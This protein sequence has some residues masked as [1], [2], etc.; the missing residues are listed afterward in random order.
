MSQVGFFS[1]WSHQIYSDKNT[2]SL[3]MKESTR[4]RINVESS[5]LREVRIQ[6]KSRPHKPLPAS[7]ANVLHWNVF[8]ISL[9]T[10]IKAEWSK[11]MNSRV[12][13][14]HFQRNVKSQKWSTSATQQESLK[15][16][17]LSCFEALKQLVPTEQAFIKSF[18]N[19]IH[20]WCSK[21]YCVWK[22]RI[23]KK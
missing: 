22:W 2:N 3:Q 6:F 18:I 17:H 14:E 8:T 7:T 12:Y 9:E 4:F 11:V 10:L 1:S 16:N 13:F 23:I 20:V 15:F 19:V 21:A 5:S